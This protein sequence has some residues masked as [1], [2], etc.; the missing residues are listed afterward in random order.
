MRGPRHDVSRPDVHQRT[1]HALGR[2]D[3]QVVVLQDLELREGPGLLD[4]E[5]PLVDGLGFDEVN[6]LGEDDAVLA[7]LEERVRGGVHGEALCQVGVGAEEQVDVPREC[8]ALLLRRRV[9]RPHGGLLAHDVGRLLRGE[10]ETPSRRRHRAHARSLLELHALQ[11]I[12]DVHK[13]IVVRV[14]RFHN[15][16]HTPIADFL[17]SFAEQV[18]DLLEIELA[19]PIPVNGGK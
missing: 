6:E 11:K 15:L 7:A 3:R 18:L 1:A 8:L 13:A 10:A 5:R 2:V 9:N 14:D 16:A 4:V 12:F 17:A 19:I